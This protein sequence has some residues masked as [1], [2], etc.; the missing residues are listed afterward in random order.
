M[1]YPSSSNNLN[2]TH[3]SGLVI[4]SADMNA[5]AAD[6]NAL[7]LKAG[8]GSSTPA[9]IGDVLTVTGAGSSAFQSNAGGL[10]WV[11]YSGVAA[12]PGS[13]SANVTAWNT[14]IS[15]LSAAGGTIFV[16][17]GNYYVNGNLAI[18]RSNVTV[19]CDSGATF[20][21]VGGFNM[22][23]IVIG[24]LFGSPTVTDVVVQGITLNG[25]AI[26]QDIADSPTTNDSTSA[27][28][29]TYVRTPTATSNTTN[30]TITVSTAAW[31]TT[32]YVGLYV[33]V[34]TGSG[35]GLSKL[36]TSHTGT[37]LTLSGTWTTN[38]TTGSTFQI[39]AQPMW[40]N[41][42]WE[43]TFGACG[44]VARDVYRLSVRNCTVSNWFNTGVEINRCGA[45]TCIENKLDNTGMQFVAGPG[46]GISMLGP[47]DN[48]TYPSHQIIISGNTIRRTSDVGI[49]IHG[50]GE[51][52][53]ACFANTIDGMSV[54]VGGADS[55]WGISCEIESSDVQDNVGTVISGNNI[56]AQNVGVSVT[57][58]GNTARNFAAIA[59]TNNVMTNI[60]GT[61][62]YLEG[63]HLNVSGNVMYNVGSGVGTNNANASGLANERDWIIAN[64]SIRIDPLQTGF[65]TAGI[66][67]RWQAGAMS[68]N[69]A[70]GAITAASNT[71]PITLTVPAWTAGN[72]PAPGNIIYVR[73]VNGNTAAN[74]MFEV[75]AVTA[76]TVTLMSSIGNG[77][78]STSAS[79]QIRYAGR[80][81]DAITISGNTMQGNGNGQ[82]THTGIYLE[83]MAGAGASIGTTTVLSS[84]SSVLTFT[85]ANSLLA[86][87]W[88][89]VSGATPGGYNGTWLVASASGTLFTAASTANPG[90]GSVQGT[91]NALNN[92]SISHVNID[93][94]NL[95]HGF[96][97]GIL[98]GG[99]TGSSTRR[100][101]ISG[102]QAWNNIGFGLN[103]ASSG[104]SGSGGLI[105]GTVTL[106]DCDFSGN[107][108]GPVYGLVHGVYS[109]TLRVSNIDGLTPVGSLGGSTPSVPATTV[110]STTVAYAC[111]VYITGGTVTATA[112]NGTTTGLTT[113]AHVYVPAG[114]TL[115]WSGS[116]A[117][118]WT[119][120]GR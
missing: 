112:V 9:N 119:W 109:P 35:A 62:V 6:V 100:V 113:P 91:V 38:P 23:G 55:R 58:T 40:A 57:N 88:V 117:P 26:L 1:P 28:L 36:I 20:T 53:V 111:D 31:G 29:G 71:T 74:G 11:V 103:L 95:I 4:A 82:G 17:G 61:G 10:S 114:Q 115:S 41:S 56:N 105:I 87:D 63:Q 7:T 43:G 83:P 12:S 97:N 77:A 3:S 66:F 34:V 47:S 78:F 39:S 92:A 104:F 50:S 108:S 76:T 90:A 80:D 19:F 51:F 22:A 69:I 75:S 37:V 65:G 25:N 68:G 32:R 8:T 59:V 79:S 27:T 106:S 21:M 84:T 93:G 33:N 13:A 116:V 60:S 101:R 110:A 99:G 42:G 48:A 94:A 30:A 102:V 52:V 98:I 5:I 72:A 86:G 81:L 49:D 64:N 85:V 73:G 24:P 16:R 70:T 15:S 45:V 89:V 2:T 44:I 107:A 67:L 46:N 96:N 54:A 120:F 14:N 118:T 18:N